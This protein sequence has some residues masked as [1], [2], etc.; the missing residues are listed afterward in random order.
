MNQKEQFFSLLSPEN[1]GLKILLFNLRS[2]ESKERVMKGGS[3]LQF[4]W[5]IFNFI[6]TF[7]GR[8]T[9]NF[10]KK[11]FNFGPYNEFQQ[12]L[13][14]ASRGGSSGEVNETVAHQ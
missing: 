2:N 4:H 11:I 9:S 5:A 7:S 1:L 3:I 10:I 8:S 6:K 14:R 12:L 13:R